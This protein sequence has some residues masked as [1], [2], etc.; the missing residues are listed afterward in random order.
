MLAIP[1]GC[2]PSTDTSRQV[3]IRWTRPATPSWRRFAAVRSRD[4][5]SSLSAMACDQ[6]RRVI[7]SEAT[8]LLASQNN[9]NA[10]SWLQV[11]TFKLR[12][13]WRTVICKIICYR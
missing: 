1:T 11:T 9:E 6:M 8:G 4:D 3:A 5:C 2:A 12:L 7:E 10:P 13:A